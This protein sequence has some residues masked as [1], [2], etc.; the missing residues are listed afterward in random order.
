MANGNDTRTGPKNPADL[1]GGNLNPQAKRFPW[2]TAVA[3]LVVVALGVLAAKQ[4]G[5]ASP[6]EKAGPRA[7]G[8]PPPVAVVVGAV[9]QQDVPIYRDGLGTVQA[10]NTVTV[11]SRVDGQLLKLS[12]QEGQDA[13]AGDVLARIDPAPFQTQVAQAQAKKAQDEAQLAFA[14]V[15]LKRDADLLATKIVTQ[16]VYDTQKAQVEQFEAAVKADQAAID[17][18]QVQLNYTTIA[19]PIDGRTGIRQVDEGNIIHAGDS[20]GIVVL[21]Q[22][23]PIS[24]IFTL[25][26]QSLGEIQQ[27]LS[28]GEM[29]V[30]AVDRDN[31]TVLDEGKLA[32]VD[33]QI[34][35]TT[36][37]I[38]IK[39]AFPNAKL[40]LWPGQFVN[41]RLLLRVQPGALVVPASVVQRGPEGAYAFVV[42]DD[43]SVEMRKVAVGQVD[44]GLALIENGLNSGE[45]VV[46]DGQYKLQPGSRIK[47]AETGRA[48]D[49]VSATNADARKT[50]AR[51]LEAPN[52]KL[53]VPEKPQTPSSNPARSEGV[54]PS[55]SLAPKG[56]GFGVWDF[57]GT[58]N[59]RLGAFGP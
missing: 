53:Q 33:N 45:R 28:Q 35:T 40:K 25:P 56:L 24:V 10:F 9:A 1:P 13:R 51:A 17:S 11:R 32:V 52:P 19:A 43:L 4:R 23:R 22:L 30:L 46:V 38:R 5:R 48:E 50:G 7:R 3:L 8:G 14:R 39:A 54:R 47:P 27:Q 29:T 58:W 44:Q 41:A 31:S 18:A 49:G 6:E 21:A 37:T 16:E 57:F 55:L 15:E 59:L 26:E 12:F 34:D 42:K 2:K 20:N 36:G